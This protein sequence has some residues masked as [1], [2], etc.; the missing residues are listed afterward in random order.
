MPP[1]FVEKLKSSFYSLERLA[2]SD[3]AAVRAL[4][5]RVRTAILQIPVL[6]EEPLNID[7]LYRLCRFLTPY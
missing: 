4:A 1:S 3:A 2:E 7:G 6:E 5:E